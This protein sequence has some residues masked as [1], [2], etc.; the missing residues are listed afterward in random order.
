MALPKTEMDNLLTDF[1]EK[2][3]AYHACRMGGNKA[4]APSDELKELWGELDNLGR[5]IDCKAQVDYELAL[6]NRELSDGQKQESPNEMMKRLRSEDH[7]PTK[8]LR[9][10]MLTAGKVAPDQRCSCHHIV[11]GHGKRIKNRITKKMVQSPVAIRARLKLH[12]V[13]IGINDA[14]NGVWL[15]SYMTD[16]P[17]WAMPKALPHANIHTLAYEKYVADRIYPLNSQEAVRTRLA[18]IAG[19]LQ[20]GELKLKGL[21]TDKAQKDLRT[22]LKN[23]GA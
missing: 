9:A 15:P 21:L 13:G 23:A 20:Q 22:A 10:K 16:V 3:Q 6:A 14:G 17:H 11:E 4:D 7:H 18:V 1:C 8:V 19:E 12:S 5:S 2:A